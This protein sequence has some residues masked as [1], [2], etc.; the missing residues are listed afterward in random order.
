MT[1]LE[2]VQQYDPVLTNITK[3]VRLFLETLTYTKSF[4]R[5]W[6]EGTCT[7]VEGWKSR[8]DFLCEWNTLYRSCFRCCRLFCWSSL[9]SGDGIWWHSVCTT[10][11]FD[12]FVNEYEYISDNASAML[13]IAYRP[14]AVCSVDNIHQQGV[15]LVTDAKTSAVEVQAVPSYCIYVVFAKLST[16]VVP[17]WKRIN[18]KTSNNGTHASFR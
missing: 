16:T 6:Q 13:V 15:A 2:C 4:V 8:L 1:V 14:L 3:R 12:R 5:P 10:L 17:V 11:S 7:A 9:P 18:W